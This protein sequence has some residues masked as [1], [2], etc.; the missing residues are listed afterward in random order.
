[1]NQ[2]NDFAEFVLSVAD[3]VT[4]TDAPQVVY[5]Q[6]GDC[7]EFLAS[8]EDFYAER[9]DSH[10]TVYYG[11]ESGEILGC[12]F[13]G[14]HSA[15]TALSKKLPGFR[16]DIVDGRIK[17]SMLFTA[18]LWITEPDEENT[19]VIT[20]RKLREVAEKNQAELVVA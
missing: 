18:A 10:V 6:D 3:S 19:L 20:Y 13:K 7:I 15:L 1:M 11:R 8:N 12:L 2:Q 5:D 4:P 9:V 14:V 16:L 17:L